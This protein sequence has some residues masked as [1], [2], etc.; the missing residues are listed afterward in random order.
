M[1]TPNTTLVPVGA[2]PTD[3]YSLREDLGSESPGLGASLI[4]VSPNGCFSSTNVQ[5]ALE[6]ICADGGGG[7]PTTADQVS[8][9]DAGGYYAS[10]NV[11]GALQEVG[12]DLQ[13]LNDA[14]SNLTASEVAVVDAGGYFVSDNVEGALQ[15]V[16][17]SLQDINAALGDITA[18]EV[19][20]SDAGGY[21]TSTD[22]E[23]ALQEL[24]EARSGSTSIDTVGTI[25]TGTWQADPISDSYIASAS[26]WDAKAE[27]SITITGTDGLQGGGNLTANRTISPLYG[28]SANTVTEGNDPRLSDS[29]S[30]TGAAD[31]DLGGTYPSPSV[32]KWQGKTLGLT[33]PFVGQSPI[34]NGTAWVP[35][36]VPA[37]G[38]GGGGVTYF[39]KDGTVAD[40]PIDGLPYPLITFQLG[41]DSSVGGTTS[42]SAIPQSPAWAVVAAF[43]TDAGIPNA[44]AIPAGLWDLNIWAQSTAAVN[45]SFF[46]IKVY[47]YDDPTAP[48]LIFASDP[49]AINEPSVIA[50]YTSVATIPQTPVL[51]TTRIYLEVEAQAS[52]AG[53]SI[54]LLYGDGT[55][56]YIR[57][58]I[59]GISGT[60]LVHVVNGV[61]ES[62]A[63]PLN[64]G[65]GSNEV[66]GTLPTGNGGTGLSTTPTN[67][68]LLIGNGFGFTLAELSE[69]VGIDILSGSGSITI[70][71]A[72][73]LSVSAASPL[74]SSGGQNPEISLDDS[75]VIAAAYGAEDKV[76]TFTVTAKGLISDASETPIQITESQVTDLTTH[77]ADK[78]PNTRTINGY[79]L[80][81]DVTL[82]KSDVGLGDV[83][84][85]AL[86]TW[87]GSTNLVTLGTVTTGVWQGSP[88]AIMYGGTGATNASDA[89]DNLGLTI[90]V[91]VQAWSATLA[92]LVA[93]TY[94][95]STSITTLGTITT[96][97]WQGS[98]I[99]DTYISSA[100]YWNA[101]V[102]PSRTIFTT[103][104]LYGGGDLSADRT[105]Y[106]PQ[107][108]AGHDGYLS[109]VDWVVFSNKVPQTRT[110]NGYALSANVTLSKSDIGLGNV[111]NTALSTWAGSANLTTLG[112]VTTG[113][114]NATP[115]SIAYGGTGQTTKTSAF[116]ALS[117]LT[118][119]GDILYGGVAGTGTRLS[120]NT[121]VTKQFLSQTGTGAV[122]AAPA[123]SVV[124]KSDV[125]LGSVENTALS[126]WAGSTNITTLGTISTGTVP[127]SLTSIVDSG[128]YFA[129]TNVETAL[130]EVGLSL[131]TGAGGVKFN[132]VHNVFQEATLGNDLFNIRYVNTG[133]GVAYGAIISGAAKGNGND[134][135]GLNVSA[136]VTASGQTARA[137]LATAQTANSG[138]IAYGLDANVAS[139]G[140]TGTATGVRA[141]ITGTSSTNIGFA[142]SIA[143][144][145]AATTNTG[146]SVSVSGVS[147]NVGGAFSVTGAATT[148]TGLAV[149]VSGA[150]SNYA[151]LFT[152]GNVGVGTA[153]P[154]QLLTIQNGNILI[155]NNNNV[156]SELRFAEPS[157]SGS[158]FTAFKAQAQASDITYTL[159]ASL[160]VAAASG[161]SFGN[162]I[163]ETSDT[164]LQAWRQQSVSVT[165]SL[166]FPA[167][168]AQQSSD[169]TITV[170]GAAIGDCVSL[171]VDSTS[172]L[173]N[174][175]Y[176]AWVSAAN[177]VTVRFNNYSTGSQ[178]PATG[179]FKVI[180]TK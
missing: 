157:G 31:G 109:S 34:W 177:T 148:N 63:S 39:L 33:T 25:T 41:L 82:T 121:T 152:A 23:G 87:P 90:G 115:I 65:G 101:K 120:G 55:P 175:C 168:N 49:T 68:Q 64:F 119:L 29:R 179:T 37:G 7:G 17:L 3:P 135:T 91:D 110:I 139:T 103:A 72:G 28:S 76:V 125:G 18:S 127:A 69:G 113:I 11:E 116:N 75:G 128:N 94:T 129:G 83:E 147:T 106:M 141:T 145:T 143:V 96:G 176:T 164:G 136:D 98:P 92:A 60:G 78:V 21:F 149:S 22:V 100:S 173:A 38:S 150:T 4:G 61:V 12:L 67:G 81:A 180:V 32:E 73:V 62:L 126:T 154:A 43:V 59:P 14:F 140:N 51:T 134:G 26:Y 70:S 138:T 36:N 178:N 162:A 104:P 45:A 158:N 108:D 30:P 42:T 54:T 66:T 97:V 80:S 171:G 114:W 151:A 9:T 146:V 89:R 93:G 19:S 117:P 13:D 160:P 40:P 50:R 52:L 5:D 167:T 53:Q 74:S 35:G 172:V 122:S 112:T 131:S 16:G 86:S 159:P 132:P 84:N 161:T 155:A 163:L 57:T 77:L 1:S 79:A 47:T 142:T 170:T 166:N 15:E 156:A 165:A 95:G 10:D 99:G 44:D 111:E 8:I 24:G 6:E 105:L 123:W 58:T 133:T 71:N 144:N 56:S 137:I 88:I 46:R 107:S 130:Q 48:V 27:G 174:S 2:P 118:T 85:T 124:T 169:L 20:I 153:T 102:D